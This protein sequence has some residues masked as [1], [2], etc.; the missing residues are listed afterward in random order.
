MQ[1]TREANTIAGVCDCH[2][3]IYDLRFKASGHVP[4]RQA[5][6][7]DYRRIQGRLGLERVVVVQSTA[8]GFDNSCTLD[9]IKQLGANARGVG[10]VNVDVTDADMERLTAS[11]IRGQ[12]YVMFADRPMGW[13]SLPTMAA[14]V[15]PFGWN[16]NLQLSGEELAQREAMLSKL[17]CDLVIDHIGRFT[18][19][20]DSKTPGVR[21]M[22]RL[23]D[24][25]R[26]WVKLSAPYHGSKS[27]PPR[28]ADIGTLA[29]EL[30]Q[31]WPERLL[32]ATN[33]PHPSV[34]GEAPDDLDL[35]KL[36][37]EWAPDESTRR[38]ILVDNPAK[39]YGFA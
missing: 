31:R 37:W 23:L 18:A 29:R 28:F 35:F 1:A 17:P 25:G 10:C 2:M 26:C 34:K 33:W 15:A 14:R 24:A 9:A 8:Y 22:H 20:A 27:G 4:P 7:T 12:R 36:V 3:H 16:I 5:T 21:V 32:W 30:V 13:D 11:G 6:V 19:P 38:Q 39:L